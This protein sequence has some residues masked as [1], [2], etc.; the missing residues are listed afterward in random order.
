MKKNIVHLHKVPNT[1]P[2]IC[3]EKNTQEEEEEEA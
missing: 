2:N 3:S 1:V